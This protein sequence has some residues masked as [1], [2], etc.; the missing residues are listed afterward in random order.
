MFGNW[1]STIQLR[2]VCAPNF[3]ISIRRLDDFASIWNRKWWYGET[4]VDRKMLIF[5]MSC[6]I[7][8]HLRRQWWK[9][10]IKALHFHE[11]ASPP[12]FCHV[13]ICEQ[14]NCQMQS[15]LIPIVPIEIH[16]GS[17]LKRDDSRR[18]KFTL[19]LPAIES[20]Q[21]VDTQ[22][23]DSECLSVSFSYWFIARNVS[24]VSFTKQS[25]II[26]C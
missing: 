21:M 9:R 13:F 15:I 19:L 11:G 24:F 14:W 8:R 22:I 18:T 10:M 2:W 3:G 1:N 25:A 16:I 26:A 17:L 4:Q 20:N 5:K 12:T 23:K 6:G 7:L